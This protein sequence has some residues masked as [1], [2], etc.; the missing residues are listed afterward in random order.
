M[1]ILV[2]KLGIT[3]IW[4]LDFDQKNDEEGGDQDEHTCESFMS[5]AM[6]TPLPA[7]HW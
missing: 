4:S 7:V 2:E 5:E 6:L 3:Q 1:I